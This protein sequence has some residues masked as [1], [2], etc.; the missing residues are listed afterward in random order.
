MDKSTIIA[1]IVA[2]LTGAVSAG[3]FKFYEFFLKQKREIAKD[4][5]KNKAM[6]RN[7]LIDRVEKL[8]AE[9]A[10]NI[11][12]IMKLMTSVTS[13]QVEMDYM[14]RDNEILRLKLDALR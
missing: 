6:Y 1:A 13:L 10:T 3:A 11:E 8:E 14:K 4:D 9:R 2:A 12:Q 5:Q 7:D